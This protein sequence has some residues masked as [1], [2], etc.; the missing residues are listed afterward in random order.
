[1]TTLILIIAFVYFMFNA[2][3]LG[4]YWEDMADM[5]WRKIALTITFLIFFGTFFLLYGAFADH[6][7]H[8]WD[9][10]K[11]IFMFYFT[12]TYKNLTEE[13]LGELDWLAKAHGNT[14]I[15]KKLKWQTRMVFKRHKYVPFSDLKK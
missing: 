11:F 12:K 3:V 13:K 15:G 10:V 7:D 5:K 8:Y 4:L 1:M 6:I 2:F 9:I 14:I